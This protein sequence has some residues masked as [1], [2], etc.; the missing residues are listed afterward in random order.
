MARLDNGLQTN[1]PPGPD[2]QSCG[3]LSTRNYKRP[4]WA[5]VTINKPQSD[6]MAVKLDSS[7]IVERFTFH[8]ADLAPVRGVSSPDGTKMMYA[9]DWLGTAETNAYVVGMSIR[10]GITE[11]NHVN[12]LSIFPNP[13]KEMLNISFPENQNQKTQLQIFNSMYLQFNGNIAQGN[14]NNTINSNKYC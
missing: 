13:A 14:F 2:D 4:G 9:S 7:G 5:Y 10:T 12:E 6:I 11:T 1:L 8:R 3:Y